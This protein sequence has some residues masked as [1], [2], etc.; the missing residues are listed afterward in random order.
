[1]NIDISL[2]T[3]KNPGY[4]K[5][6]AIQDDRGLA[7]HTRV[8]FFCMVATSN[9]PMPVT[10]DFDR[11]PVNR[12]Q[13][14]LKHLLPCSNGQYKENMALEEAERE[15]GVVISK[16]IYLAWLNANGFIYELGP[17]K[18]DPRVEI[19]IFDYEGLDGE[20]GVNLASV[21]ELFGLEEIERYLT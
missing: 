8:L 21:Y 3:L 17:G 15:H 6:Y 19:D 4:D 18:F 9:S 12:Q 7:P 20:E 5:L 13:A 10:F 11:L 14:I 1:M 2:Y 16:L